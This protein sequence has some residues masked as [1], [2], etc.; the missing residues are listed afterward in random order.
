M[1]GRK[2][3]RGPAFLALAPVLALSL[4]GCAAGPDY[5][6]PTPGALSLGAR[7]TVG[8][9]RS[10]ASDAKWW[11]RFND[12]VLDELVT[13]CLAGDLDIAAGEQRLIEAREALAQ[14]RAQSLPGL[15]ASRT[16]QQSGYRRGPATSQ[17][18]N[19][20]EVS[21]AID[22]FGA[23]KRD[24][25]AARASLQASGYDLADIRIA[26]AAEAA[27]NYIDYRTA[28]ERAAIARETLQSLTDNAEIAGWRARAGLVSQLD[29]EQANAQR[30]QTAATIPA[31]EQSAKDAGYRLAVL[32]GRPPGGIDTILSA[33]GGIPAGPAGIAVGAPLDLLRRR[34]DVRALERRLAA[35][36][37]NVGVAEAALTPSLTLTGSIVNYATGAAL[38][39]D[40]GAL[41]AGISQTLFDGGRLR[42]VVRQRRAALDLALIDYRKGVLTAVEDVEKALAALNAADAKGVELAEQVR[43]SEEAAALARRKYHSGL[44]DFLALQ[45]AERSL[46]SARDGLATA[47]GE[48][49]R[50]TVQLYLALG[51]GWEP[52]PLS[53]SKALR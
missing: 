51:G 19:S 45:E 5:R 10:L 22:L 52:P 17:V 14:S 12:P 37:A 7:Y 29:A 16:A 42:S 26:S 35:A 30:A 6:S 2:G 32:T 40:T 31:I 23:H 25:E 1:S 34:P 9:S 13:L 46:L 43:A 47:R 41:A 8:E 33:P 48:A 3:S 24:I 11:T 4:A 20:L 18:T 36:S 38:T 21:W 44:S 15:T 27:R 50:A 39:R 49:A 28:L 53:P